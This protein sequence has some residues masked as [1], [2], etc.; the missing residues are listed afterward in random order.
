MADAGSGLSALRCG[1]CVRSPGSAVKDPDVRCKALKDAQDALLGG[2]DQHSAAAFGALVQLEATVDLDREAWILSVRAIYTSLESE[3][4][5]AVQEWRSTV[6]TRRASR[7]ALGQLSLWAVE[8]KTRAYA[9]L[10]AW[11]RRRRPGQE[12]RDPPDGECAPLS[13]TT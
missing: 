2:T 10:R 8:A 13:W 9:S 5:L 12:R 11:N 3:L 4:G 6:R 1:G 7:A